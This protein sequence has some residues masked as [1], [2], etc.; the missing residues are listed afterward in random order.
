M[1]CEY[2]DAGV[3][4]SC[5]SMGVPY[6]Q[7]LAAKDVGVRQVLA[8]FGEIRWDAPVASRESRFR[9]KAKLVVGGTAAQPTLGILDGVGRG[10]DLARCGLY[11]PGITAAI[12]RLREFVTRTGLEPYDVPGRRGE[13]KYLILTETPDG[14]FM[15]RV[16][17]RSSVAVGA[18]RAELPWLLGALPRLA[19]V[20]VNLHP[21]HK[22]VIEGE[23][24]IVLTEQDTV[25]IRLN[26]VRLH[27]GPRAFFQ[28]NTEI[29]AALYRTAT[30]WLD[31]VSGP[32]TD[33]YCGVG[34][35]AL[36]LAGVGREVLGV[37]SSA[38]AVAAARVAAAE[39]VEGAEAAGVAV[40]PVRFAVADAT[41]AGA[42][43]GVVVVNPPRRG[44]GPELA[45]TLSESAEAV[46]Y[47]S[48]NPISLARDLAAMPRLR[49]VRA[50]VFDMFPQTSHSETLVLL[51]R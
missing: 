49:P 15:L 19:V 33:L 41:A 8:E 51:E 43:G 21:E 34:G 17:A 24:E 3:C 35:F 25:A 18:V 6:G 38:L 10:V 13:L 44:I 27:L 5:T 39:L 46:L 22:A 20:S 29:A 31:G 28:T 42:A 45:A 9:N 36:H 37:E 4:R 48:C 14:E 47:S 50:Q 12:P 30:E 26:R 2:F 16:V 11:L 7:Q 32:V 40:G 1:H 23:E